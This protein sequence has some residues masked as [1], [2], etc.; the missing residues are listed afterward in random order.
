M[1]KYFVDLLL[2]ILLILSIII[3]KIIAQKTI[4]SL[5]NFISEEIIFKIINKTL[6][7]IK[8]NIIKNSNLCIDF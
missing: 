8:D 6:L 2:V 3:V 5:I 1:L 7:L 4:T